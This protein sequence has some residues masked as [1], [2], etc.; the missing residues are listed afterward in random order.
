MGNPC[1]AD[2]GFATGLG[3]GPMIWAYP[4]GHLWASL[5]GTH[6]IHGMS[7]LNFE[8]YDRA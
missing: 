3:K 6:I 1:G 5:Y 7:M 4:C 2:L 8:Y